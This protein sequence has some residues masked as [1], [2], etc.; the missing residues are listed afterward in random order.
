MG[1]RR[2]LE[3]DRFEIISWQP[4]VQDASYADA[5]LVLIGFSIT[6]D[7]YGLIQEL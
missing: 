2:P 4:R 3:P 5:H 6:Y 1:L 7:L